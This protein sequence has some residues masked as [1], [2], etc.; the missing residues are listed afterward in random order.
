MRSQGEHSTHPGTAELP[1][2]AGP[3][4]LVVGRIPH[5]DAFLGLDQ[6]WHSVVPS[7]A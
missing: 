7:N 2:M 5:L 6:S 3:V 1:F 4:W